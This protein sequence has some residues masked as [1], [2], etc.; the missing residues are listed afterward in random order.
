MDQVQNYITDL[1][2]EFQSQKFREFAMEEYG[3]SDFL[4]FLPA[5]QMEVTE[6]ALDNWNELHTPKLSYEQLAQVL[7][8]AATQYHISALQ[9]SGLIESIYD[10]EKN[11][12]AY[13]L[14]DSAKNMNVTRSIANFNSINW[15]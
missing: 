6:T 4:Q 13:Q 10:A 7:A 1:M 9:D 14:T 3:I 15:N 11:E 2:S 12:V 8:R 5:L